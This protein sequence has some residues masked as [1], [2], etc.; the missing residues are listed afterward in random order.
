MQDN[1]KFNL[2]EIANFLNKYVKSK[3]FTYITEIEE[4][5]KKLFFAH[6][7]KFWKYH[8]YDEILN[9]IAPEKYEALS[10]DTSL[11]KQAIDNKSSIFSNHATSDKYYIPAIDNPLKLKIKSLMI[12]PIVKGRKVL[13]ILKIYRGMRQGK[14]FTKYD[15]TILKSLSVLLV[16][17]IES[18]SIEK[19]ELL[20]LL[21]EK[22]K[23]K[24][25]LKQKE[26]KSSSAFRAF[27]FFK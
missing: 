14:V 13:G 4:A 3:D 9:L 19:V 2:K 22:T 16:K 8:E 27:L 21:G 26:N 23:K 17:I 25:P 1:L 6:T 20:G 12:F 10:L 24:I 7:V 11:T 18:K 15:E 5:L